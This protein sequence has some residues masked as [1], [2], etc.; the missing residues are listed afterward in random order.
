MRLLLPSRVPAF[1]GS[2]PLFK[3]KDVHASGM[4]IDFLALTR[5]CCLLCK[6]CYPLCSPPNESQGQH[7]APDLAVAKLPSHRASKHERRMEPTG[8]REGALW[9]APGTHPTQAWGAVP[10]TLL[11]LATGIL[12]YTPLRALCHLGEESWTYFSSH[13]SGC[14]LGL[15]AGSPPL[16]GSPILPGKSPVST[17]AQASEPQGCLQKEGR[18][19]PRWRAGRQP[20]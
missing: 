15:E 5:L 20:C 17:P 16:L 12:S 13:N 10:W 19:S 2:Q 1:L 8:V 7:R 11:S 6:P 3:N 4:D 18:W 9:T 14:F